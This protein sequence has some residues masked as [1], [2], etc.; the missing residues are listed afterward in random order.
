MTTENEP[1]KKTRARKTTA[2]DPAVFDPD[3]EGM[4]A[5]QH[6]APTVLGIPVPDIDEDE[7]TFSASEVNKLFPT[8]EQDE[9]H[10]PVERPPVLA[11]NKKPLILQNDIEMGLGNDRKKLRMGEILRE[12]DLTNEQ[13][14]WFLR[15]GTLGFKEPLKIRQAKA[16]AAAA[17]SVLR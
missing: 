5:A 6:A 16:K 17:N 4:N 2:K 10:E 14:R 12:G 9:V 3:E 13:I 8:E 1:V 11:S 15:K 7:E